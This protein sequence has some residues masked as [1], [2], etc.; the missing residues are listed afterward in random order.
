MGKSATTAAVLTSILT[1]GMAAQPAAAAADSGFNLRGPGSSKIYGNFQVRGGGE[2]VRQAECK[3]RIK[4]RFRASGTITIRRYSDLGAITWEK[5]K[6][7]TKSRVGAGLT[8][9]GDLPGQSTAGTIVCEVRTTIYK[10]GK[11]WGAPRGAQ[12][13]RIT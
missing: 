9:G 7:F 1:L 4:D 11:V 8:T 6:S 13:F 10:K 2:Y 12:T 3:V 5:T